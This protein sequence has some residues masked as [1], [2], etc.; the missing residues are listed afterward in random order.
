MGE[1]E[2]RIRP[3]HGPIEY[4]ILQ[5]IWRSA[6]DATH[7]FLADSDR[8]EIMQRLVTDYFPQVEVFVAEVDGAPVGFSGLLDHKIEMLFV[9]DEARGR[10]VGS[11]LVA[12]A[13]AQRRVT[14]VDVNEQNPSAV[15]FYRSRGFTV[16]ARSPYDDSGRPYPLLHM[17]RATGLGS[18][19]TSSRRAV[20]KSAGRDCR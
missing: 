7:D 10:G 14:Q 16:S 11:R 8:D 15:A 20:A 2:I 1:S 4:P 17:V 5:R 19:D 3:T 9:T 13:I 18:P 6:V 12:H